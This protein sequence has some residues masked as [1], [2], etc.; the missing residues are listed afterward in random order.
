M[1]N[2]VRLSKQ[3][4]VRTDGVTESLEMIVL[5]SEGVNRSVGSAIKS[6]D[7]YLKS[8]NILNVEGRQ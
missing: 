8:Y 6:A 2:R 4:R 7:K 1:L 5:S 3:V